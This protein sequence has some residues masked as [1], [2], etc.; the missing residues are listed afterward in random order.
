MRF[1]LYF[2]ATAT[3]I[4]DDYSFD[5]KYFLL[6]LRAYIISNIDINRTVVIYEPW[7]KKRN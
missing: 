1:F 2:I 6:I 5:R 7:D 3:V 4:H